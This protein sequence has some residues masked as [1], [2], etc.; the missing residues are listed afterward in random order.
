[1]SAQVYVPK[2]AK[3]LQRVMREVA[4]RRVTHA[5]E[6]VWPDYPNDDAFHDA[7][8]MLKKGE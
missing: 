3:E 1:M 4:E 6:R 7:D 8:R 5:H 2:D